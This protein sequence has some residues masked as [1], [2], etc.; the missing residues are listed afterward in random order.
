MKV[1]FLDIDGVLNSLDWYKNRK[2]ICNR[3]WINEFD[4]AAVK[5]LI[6]IIEKTGV[7]LVLSSTWRRFH[8][9][10]EI[11]SYLSNVSDKNQDWWRRKFIG[12]TPKI[13]KNIYEPILRGNEINT[14]LTTYTTKK[15]VRK[16]VIVDDDSDM[17]EEQKPYFIKINHDF[18]LTDNDV[19]L[20]INILQN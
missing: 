3:D 12:I 10:D 6:Y 15:P 16:Y 11:S 7:E 14:W 18:G 8:T 19:E 5:R 1:L 13:Y 17:L 4:P 2:H 20:I 9:L